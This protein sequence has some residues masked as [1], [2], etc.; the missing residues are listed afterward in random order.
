MTAAGSCMV[1]LFK[2][3]DDS[4]L[5]TR[6]SVRRLLQKLSDSS[7]HGTAQEYCYTC[8]PCNL[9]FECAG[10]CSMCDGSL[11]LAPCS[12]TNAELD[13]P[14]AQGTPPCWQQVQTPA[15]T[16][17]DSQTSVQDESQFIVDV[18]GLCLAADVLGPDASNESLVHFLDD[19]LHHEEKP[20][21][22]NAT[23]PK[24][25]IELAP[26]MQIPTDVADDLTEEQK[27]MKIARLAEESTL[28]CPR[29]KRR[30]YRTKN[31]PRKIELLQPLPVVTMGN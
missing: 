10:I 18:L 2:N 14:A 13:P 21:T 27:H 30:R 25:M 22:P 4:I 19:A 3:L 28:A 12:T 29:P 26:D 24:H 9:R 20:E 17:L 31:K 7:I 16:I 8:E 5:E 23:Q 1:S 15:P 11:K 6:C